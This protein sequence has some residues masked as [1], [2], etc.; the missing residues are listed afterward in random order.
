M[1]YFKQYWLLATQRDVVT[2][3]GTSFTARLQQDIAKRDMM[4]VDHGAH[5]RREFID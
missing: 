2:G 3:H 1:L 4:S 5:L